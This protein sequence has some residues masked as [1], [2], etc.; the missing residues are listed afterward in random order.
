MAV[1]TRTYHTMRSEKSAAFWLSKFIDHL[2]FIA[3]VVIIL[4]LKILRQVAGENAGIS[5]SQAV[6]TIE[7]LLE[8]S[9]NLEIGQPK[10]F[11]IPYLG[12]IY[13]PCKGSHLERQ[14]Q[15]TNF[16][17]SVSISE[18]NGLQQEQLHSEALNMQAQFEQTQTQELADL[19][20]HIVNAG[21]F[22]QFS[23]AQPFQIDFEWDNTTFDWSLTQDWD[24]EL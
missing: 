20:T 4:S 18:P 3:V 2:G 21:N 24:L 17:E 19:S 6:S 22:N 23:T 10:Q 16:L 15:A 13:I 9:K 5:A 12:V 11:V 1:S 7:H 14:N 8:E